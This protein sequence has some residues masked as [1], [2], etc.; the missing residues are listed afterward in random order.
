MGRGD[1]LSE[2]GSEMSKRAARAEAV[3]ELAFKRSED[4]PVDFDRAIQY[5]SEFTIEDL[6]LCASAIDP[7]IELPLLS[8]EEQAADESGYAAEEKWVE[9]AREIIV[10]DLQKAR[11]WL[12][13]PQS[14][15]QTHAG[16]A[17]ELSDGKWIVRGARY[18]ID[19]ED[20]LSPYQRFRRLLIVGS[21][22]DTGYEKAVS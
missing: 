15:G 14:A 8:E 18:P 11:E 5:V 19:R 4:E 20:Y 13:D 22:G 17:L 6:D 2:I 7:L 3:S 9:K 16:P 12:S 21:L 10:D 1:S